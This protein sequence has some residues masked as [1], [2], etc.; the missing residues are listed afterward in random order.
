MMDN[1]MLGLIAQAV[2]SWKTSLPV[3]I[4]AAAGLA[5]GIGSATGIFSVVEAVLLKPLPYANADRYLAVYASWRRAPDAWTVFSYSDYRDYVA[6]NRTL[7][8]F[9]CYQTYA[10]NVTFHDQPN[11][12]PGA[13]ISP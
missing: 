7:E 1:R 5:I 9:G 4:L 11:H 10:F 12:I 3:A 6:R 8:A 2:R 13:Q